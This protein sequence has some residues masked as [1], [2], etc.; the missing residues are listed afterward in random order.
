MSPVPAASIETIVEGWR[1]RAPAMMG[2]LGAALGTKVDALGIERHERFEQLLPDPGVAGLVATLGTTPQAEVLAL[3][4]PQG[5][6]AALPTDDS[7]VGGALA[8]LIA[9]WASALL[10]HDVA[11]GGVSVARVPDVRAALESRRAALEPRV[12]AESAPAIV[13]FLADAQGGEATL[14]FVGAPLPVSPEPAPEPAPAV[15]AV[16]QPSAAPATKRVVR[17]RGSGALTSYSKSLLKIRLP[18]TVTLAAKKQPLG[19][20]IE[21]GPGAI[22]H[23]NKSCE[24]MLDLEVGGQ[25]IGQGEPIKVGDKFGLRLTSISLPRERFSRWGQANG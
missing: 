1:K 10:G 17:Q 20:I 2:L 21:L 24:E 7:T 23:F 19:R 18:V 16:Q 12:T 22:I 14:V 6:S 8:A 3:A 11:P 4:D 5:W 9:Q 25:S 15:A 13:M